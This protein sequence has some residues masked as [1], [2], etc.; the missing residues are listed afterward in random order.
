M[1]KLQKEFC[2]IV[3]LMEQANCLNL[4]EAYRM[5]G[6]KAKTPR[7]ET[8]ASQLYKSKKVKAFLARARGEFTVSPAVRKTAEDIIRTYETLSEVKLTDFLKY[9]DKGITLIDSDKVPAEIMK[10]L[11]S[12]T[13][14]ETRYENKKGREGVIR[15][16][17]IDL[18]RRNPALDML[19]KIRGLFE[20]HLEP[21][22]R[23]IIVNVTK[24]YKEKQNDPE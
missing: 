21:E 1:T 2:E 5:A 22:D 24:T 3:F 12:I 17:K 19:A 10:G 18:E 4:T 16:V 14:T 9:S 20:K 15:R 7:A 6:Y 23:D 8:N 13:M 11:K